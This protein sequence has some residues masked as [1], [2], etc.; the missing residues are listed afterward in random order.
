MNKYV[1]QLSRDNKKTCVNI[2]EVKEEEKETDQEM[3]CDQLNYYRH[4][5]YYVIIVAN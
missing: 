1:D 3:A 5:Y 2:Q 4:Y